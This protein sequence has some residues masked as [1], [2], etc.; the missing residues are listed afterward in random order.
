MTEKSEEIKEDIVKEGVVEKPIKD[1]FYGDKSDSDDS[2]KED[3]EDKDLDDKEVKEDVESKKDEAVVD[4]NKK[5]EAS[6]KDVEVKLSIP[7]NLAIPRE[8]IDEIESY[9]KD[10]GLSSE[11]AQRMLDNENEAVENYKIANLKAYNEMADKDWPKMAMED[12][13]IGGDKFKESCAMAKRAIDQFA[14][15][16]LT[17][18]LNSTGYGN[19]P[20]V[21]RCFS[22]IGKLI[23]DDKIIFGETHSVE[24]K[25][26]AEIL[27]GA[28]K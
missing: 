2:D 27:Y 20:E 7:E 21:I 16:E 22:N 15:E 24:E 10:Q 17:K 14:S 5:E 12:K 26:A 18:L 28:T 13:E 25:T 23:R 19:H 6:K 4:K 9:A 1:V 3:N 8:R 11:V